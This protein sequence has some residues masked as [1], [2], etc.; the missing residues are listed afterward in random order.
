MTATNKTDRS[1]RG[2]KGRNV[3]EVTGPLWACLGKF[4]LLLTLSRAWRHTSPFRKAITGPGKGN[5]HSF[6]MVLL[7]A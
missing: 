2:G 5:T 4:A 1:A 3:K 6:C 7:K